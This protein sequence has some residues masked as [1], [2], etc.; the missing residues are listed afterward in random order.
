MTTTKT[1][2]S[3]TT[4]DSPDDYDNPWKEVI[5]RY[6]PEFLELLFPHIA[7]QIDWSQGYKFQDK[8]LQKIARE[9][10]EGNRYTDK[11]VEVYRLD[12]C[13][14]CVMIH[15]EVQSQEQPGFAVRMLV[16]N[17]RLRDYYQVPIVSLAVLADERLSWRPDRVHEGLWGCEM[18]FTYPIAKLAD[19][20]ERWDELEAATNPFAL[21]V[22]AH[23][24]TQET[25]HQ[26]MERKRWKVLLIR[27]LYRKGYSKDNVVG[28]LRFLDWVM[29]LPK[30]LDKVCWD[31]VK[32]S[33][34]GK[35]MPYVMSIERIS[36]EDGLKQGWQQGLEQGLERGKQQGL[37]QAIALGVKLRFGNNAQTQ[38][39]LT[40]IQ[41]ITDNDVLQKLVQAL[42]TV[43]SLEELQL[44]CPSEA[45]TAADAPPEQPPTV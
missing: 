10:K 5:E 15:I 29:Q 41:H 9:A 20:R 24:K 7:C 22:M 6:F 11:L 23:L 13:K 39:L 42:E 43:A 16:Y 8:V 14:I 3:Q 25:R 31:E 35:Q 30:E 18:T 33:E 28:L 4:T 12:G 27:M 38:A 2:E 17:C 26:Q 44:L 36:R 40:R 1:D 37:Q 32:A 45:T 34:E 19:Y 21:V